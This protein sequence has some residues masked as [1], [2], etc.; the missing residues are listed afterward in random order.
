MFKIITKRYLYNIYRV[1]HY[2]D[3]GVLIAVGIDNLYISDEFG[4]R[5]LSMPLLDHFFE[6]VPEIAMRVWRV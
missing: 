5:L 3:I 6:F 1:R 2:G 4:A